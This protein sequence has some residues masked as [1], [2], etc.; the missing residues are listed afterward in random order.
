[1]ELNPKKCNVLETGENSR[2]IRWKCDVKNEEIDKVNEVL[3]SDD[4]R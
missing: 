1:M 2:K 3:G 4:I